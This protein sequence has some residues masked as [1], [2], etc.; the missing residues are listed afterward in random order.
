MR[1]L[2]A[3][4]ASSPR[5]KRMST[6]PTS[7]RKVVRE[8][9]GKSDI[10]SSASEREL[11]PVPSDQCDNT[12]HHGKGVMIEITGLQ[13]AGAAGEV[14]RELGNTVRSETVDDRPIAAL[15]QD[16]AQRLGGTDQRGVEQLV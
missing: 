16:A 13:P 3:T 4:K 1:A 2:L 12:D 11:V 15:P 7:G 5:V 9:I 10:G 6:A 8:R 14:D